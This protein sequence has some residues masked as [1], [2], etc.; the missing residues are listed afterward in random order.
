[1]MYQMGKVLTKYQAHGIDLVSDT[2]LPEGVRES[3][4][5]VQQWQRQ[6]ERR[7]VRRRAKTQVD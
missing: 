5:E 2:L 6:M 1:M 3:L 4:A 7:E